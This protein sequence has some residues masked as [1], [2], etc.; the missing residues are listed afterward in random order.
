MKTFDREFTIQGVGIHSGA[1]VT[2]TAQPAKSAVIDFCRSDLP[3]P[4]IPALYNRVGATFLR[5]TTLGNI[6]GACIQTI[7]HVMAALY[8][9]G[10]DGA[11]FL[12]DG[13]ETP[14]LD[15]SAAQFCRI[16]SDKIV[17]VPGK[18]KKIVIKK[19]IIVYPQSEI[20]NP[21]NDCFVRLYPDSRGLAVSARLIYPE[22]IIGDQS[23]DFLFDGT[24]KSQQEF[25]QGIARARTFGKLE[26]WEQLKTMGMGRGCSEENVIVIAPGNESVANR[27]P[28]ELR[29]PNEFVRHKI[30]DIIGDMYTAGGRVIGGV[31][32]Y[33]GSHALN[34]AAL[35]KLFETQDNY[36][37]IEE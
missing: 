32:S 25:L 8:I 31:E 28:Y 34:N 27:H 13:P 29:W 14:I 21:S 5:N 33:K 6:R 7:E 24:D 20:P 11:H 12:V 30:I 3:D 17:E 23:Y 2:M 4:A 10:I 1:P 37:I 16:F 22:K 35:K 26:E 9:M 18:M 19:E 36:D 15:G